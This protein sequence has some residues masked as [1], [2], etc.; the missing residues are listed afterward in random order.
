MIEIIN[1][2]S[3]ISALLEF[4]GIILFY[5]YRYLTNI[6][7]ISI[8]FR[9]LLNEIAMLNILLNQLYMLANETDHDKRTVFLKFAKIG[10]LNDY[11]KFLHTI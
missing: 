1:I 8:K 11:I 6:A 4:S 5:D 7:K 9:R 3:G 10:A 2:I